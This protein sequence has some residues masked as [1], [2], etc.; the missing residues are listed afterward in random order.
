MKRKELN[1]E[2]LENWKPVHLVVVVDGKIAN[3]IRCVFYIGGKGYQ[4]YYSLFNGE[5]HIGFIKHCDVK[6]YMS[7]AEIIV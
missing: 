6:P 4:S 1:K 7:N 5:K 2:I 3:A